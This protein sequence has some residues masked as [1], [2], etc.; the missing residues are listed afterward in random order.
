[1]ATG[2]TKFH[3][4][5]ERELSHIIDLTEKRVNV[6]ITGAQGIGKTHILDNLKLD[7]M[8]RIDDTS[9]FRLTLAGT[10]LHLM[11]GDKDKISQMLG[12]NPEIITKESTK[13][14]CE[15]LCQITEKNEYTIVIDRADE[16]TPSVV[17]ALEMLRNH[18]HFIVAARQVK[19]SAATWLTNFEK[20]QIKPLSRQETMLLISRASNDF[21]N[22]IEDYEAFKNHVWNQ[23][24]G[25]PQFTL[26]LID[27][28]RKEGFVSAEKVLEYHHTAARSEI[29]MSTVILL[30]LACLM[31]FRYVAGEVNGGE[32]SGAFK[33]IGGIALIFALFAR[34]IF[35]A[36]KRKYV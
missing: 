28:F 21:R 7:N 36:A 23:A 35:K 16:L 22:Q 10:L 4:G 15:L 2:W 19:I 29:D 1:M 8:L 5:R 12:L 3:V 25:V 13:R 24:T 33:L 32:D 6:L 34:Q 14:L 20:V 31:I 11:E 26:E 18:F 30:G 17:K 9:R 27:R